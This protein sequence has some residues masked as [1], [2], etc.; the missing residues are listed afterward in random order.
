MN[1][2]DTS[3]SADVTRPPRWFLLLCLLL[4]GWLVTPPRE[5][6]AQTSDFQAKAE[7]AAEEEAHASALGACLYGYPRAELWNR[8]QNETR[9][10]AEDQVIFAPVNRFYYFDR[11]ARPGDGRFIEAPQ[12]DT[13]YGSAY[14][15]LSRGPVVLRIPPMEGRYY[16]ALVVDAAG[17]VETR[18]S[19]QV[20]GPQGDVD[21][22]FLG[23]D[24]KTEI[25]DGMRKL[26]QT[27]NDL[28]VL[29]RVACAGGADEKVAAGVLKKF[30]LSELSAVATRRAEGRNTPVASQPLVARAAPHQ[31]LEFFQVLDQMLLRNPVPAEDRGLLAR[32]ERLGL[33]AG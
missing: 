9:R 5:L 27:A 6:S 25:P 14:L 4:A 28:W 29:M 30:T 24:D 19:S 20:T 23:P 12:N 32:W 3:P 10:V 22:V 7:S 15:D 33:G 8:I 13:L 31:T 16:V 21:L 17:G 2:R 11:L 18:I 1:G 26:P